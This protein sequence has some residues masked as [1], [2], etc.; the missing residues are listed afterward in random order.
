MKTY[1]GFLVSQIRQLQGRTFERLL[2][3]S[4][5]DAFNGPQ[6]RILYVLWE[7]PRLTITQVGKLT[8]LAKTTLTSM[9]DRME[10]SGLIRREP[11]PA[12]RRQIYVCITEKALG[13]RAAY[14]AVSERMNVLFYQGFS[15]EEV[16]A[17]EAALRRIIDNLETEEERKTG[18]DDGEG[19]EGHPKACR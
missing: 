6:G 4:G 5:I 10:Q 11:D 12:N 9:L 14:D 8:S 17:F 19:K 3:E 13:Y 7:H 15:E 2:K 1:G 16:A 18:H